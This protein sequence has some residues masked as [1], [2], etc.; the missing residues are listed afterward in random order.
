MYVNIDVTAVSGC[1]ISSNIYRATG[2]CTGL[3]QVS[4]LFGAPLDDLHNL[5][6]LTVG[7]LYYVQV[8]YPV[9]GA[10]GNAGSAQYCIEVGIPDIPCNT[11]SDPCGTAQGF[12]ITPSIP[13][14]IADCGTSPFRPPLQP[15]SLNRY[16]YDF[17]AT[18]TTVSFNVIIT[19]NCPASGNVTSFAWDLYNDPACGTAIQT[20]VLPD[21]TFNGLTIGN[22]YVFCY[23]FNV[24]AVCAHAQHCPYFVGATTPLPVTWLDIEATVQ[25]NGKVGV[26][27]STAS[28]QNNDHFTV[29]RSMDA[30]SFEAIGRVDGQGD[31]FTTTHY[32]FLDHFPHRGVSYYRVKQTDR[33]GSYDYSRTVPVVNAPPATSLIVSPNPVKDDAIL[34]IA[35]GSANT[36][37]LEIRD[38]RG[39]IVHMRPMY[40]YAG[41]HSVPLDIRPLAEG[42]YLISIVS[43][44]ERRSLRFIKE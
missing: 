19:S 37:T 34:T 39:R 1:N 16:C 25:E 26:A 18:N 28:E 24:P 35:M 12:S 31:S 23:T 36:L 43:Q 41:V 7:G 11:C 14:V 8:C 38:A 42:I 9:G 22:S 20:G 30:L 3:T 44:N 33:D 13:E 6:G 17:T 32:F 2:T 15:G 21:L 27:W 10:C 40:L 5:T 29:E 4:C